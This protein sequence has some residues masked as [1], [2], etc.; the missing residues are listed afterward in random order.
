VPGADE[1]HKQMVKNIETAK[2]HLMAAKRG[3]SSTMIKAKGMCTLMKMI[4]CC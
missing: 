2:R 1:L 4:G 3:K